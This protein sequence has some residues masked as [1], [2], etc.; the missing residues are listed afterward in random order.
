VLIVA[1]SLGPGYNDI[2]KLL[3]ERGAH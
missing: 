2:V 3:R 1:A